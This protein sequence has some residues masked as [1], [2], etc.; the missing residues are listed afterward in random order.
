MQHCSVVMAQAAG[1][2]T[3]RYLT[4]KQVLEL[5]GHVRKGEHGTWFYLVKQLQVRDKGADDDTVTRI[6]PHCSGNHS[7]WTFTSAPHIGII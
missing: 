4:F 3:P 6:M 2:C 5:S 7:S 1:Y